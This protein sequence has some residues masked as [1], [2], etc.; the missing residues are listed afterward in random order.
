MLMILCLGVKMILQKTLNAH[1]QN[2]EEIEAA[3]RY[4]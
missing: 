3:A 1:L 2:S 4:K